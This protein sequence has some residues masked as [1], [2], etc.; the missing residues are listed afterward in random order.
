MVLAINT[1]RG[2]VTAALVAPAVA[3]LFI[4]LVLPFIAM[5]VFSV[6]DR[7]PEGGYQPAFTFAQ[8]ANLP[9]RAAAFWN[10]LV[11]APIGSLLCLIVAYPVAYYL[12]V[13][14]SPR[15]RLLL[16]PSLSCHSGQAFWYEPMRG[17]I[18]SDRAASQISWA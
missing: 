6:G 5:V 18:S 8:F 3:W 11:L 7:A 16:Y 15:Y 17:C 1:K 13:K 14:A 2:M 9:S 4:F 10:T 12:A